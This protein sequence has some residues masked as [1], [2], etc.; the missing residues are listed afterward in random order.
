MFPVLAIMLFCAF[1]P[2]PE[3]QQQKGVLDVS[4]GGT[5]R[6]SRGQLAT[7]KMVRAG[8]GEDFA[9]DGLKLK[10]SSFTF[11]HVPKSGQPYIEV[12]NGNYFTSTIK[13]RLLQVKTGDMIIL[14]EVKVKG[15]GWDYNRTINGKVLTVY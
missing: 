4:A 1:T 2:I 8:F 10:V 11:A 9:F 13:A 6:I 3:P 12:V 5:D 7:Y 15:Q 14:S